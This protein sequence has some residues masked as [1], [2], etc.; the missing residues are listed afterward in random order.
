MEIP[1]HSKEIQQTLPSYE[2]LVLGLHRNSAKSAM[3]SEDHSGE[4]RAVSFRK[5][6][7]SK[8][9][10]KDSTINVSATRTD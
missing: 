9:S 5:L 3:W 1:T 7:S 10:N 2:R 8:S 6:S 4:G